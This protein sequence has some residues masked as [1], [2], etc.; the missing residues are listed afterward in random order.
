LQKGDV[1]IDERRTALL[2]N[3]AATLPFLRSFFQAR[4]LLLP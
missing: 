4:L 3:A 2:Q 1:E